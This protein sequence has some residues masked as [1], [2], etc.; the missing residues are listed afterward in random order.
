MKTLVMT[1]GL[2]RSGKSTWAKGDGA[3]I[4][5]PDAIRL[6]LHGKAY[7][8]QAEPYVWAIARTMVASLFEAGHDKVILDACNNTRKRRDEWRSGRWRRL[9]SDFH[10][11]SAIC[12]ERAKHDG[13]DDLVSVIERMAEQREPLQEDEHEP[14]EA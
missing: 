5:S 14:P 7:I 9:F 4:V 2:P 6:A 12:I 11:S 13:R 10:V 8:S 3:P 1:V